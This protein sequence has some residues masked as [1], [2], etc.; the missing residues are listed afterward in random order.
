MLRL[1]SSYKSEIYVLPFSFLIY[2]IMCYRS[3]SMGIVLVLTKDSGAG[4]RAVARAVNAPGGGAAG[5]GFQLCSIHDSH[6][7]FP[8]I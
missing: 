8:H 4:D 2:L 7:S 6:R 5:R 1:Q 3:D